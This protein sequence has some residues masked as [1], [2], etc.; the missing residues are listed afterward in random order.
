MINNS[1]FF[2]DF[3]F[4]IEDRLIQENK[5]QKE[6]EQGQEKETRTKT[7]FTSKASNKKIGDDSSIVIHTARK[8]KRK[9]AMFQGIEPKDDSKVV[10]VMRKN[11]RSGS[12]KLN[13]NVNKSQE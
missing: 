9:T 7:Y 8:K 1:S 11:V 2:K 10:K 6:K 4:N 13:L 12:L 5:E 3:Y